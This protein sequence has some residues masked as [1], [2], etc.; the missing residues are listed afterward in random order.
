MLVI[1]QAS[2]VSRHL[3]LALVTTCGILI[4][5]SLVWESSL[6]SIWHLS[7]CGH[8]MAAA[9][10]SSWVGSVEG[11][12]I[13]WEYRLVSRYFPHLC[14]RITRE[15]TPITKRS[16]VSFLRKQ[17]IF[18][19]CYDRFWPKVLKGTIVLQSYSPSAWCAF[20]YFAGY[21]WRG[22]TETSCSIMSGALD[23]SRGLQ[24]YIIVTVQEMLNF[25]YKMPFSL[26]HSLA[27]HSVLF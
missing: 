10:S 19:L 21:E 3:Q 7:L 17:V 16:S 5:L 26:S 14:Q 12:L 13:G 25:E 27:I 8:R 4:L 23:K 1:L 11:L 2:R 20:R 22:R 15:F 24:N 9:L 18:C 6:L